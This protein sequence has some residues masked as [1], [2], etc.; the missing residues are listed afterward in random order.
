MS[1]KKHCECKLCSDHRRVQRIK[2]RG[3]VDKM[4]TLIDELEERLFMSE[5][6]LEVD[7]AILAGTWPSAKEYALGILEKCAKRETDLVQSDPGKR[8]ESTG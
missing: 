3:N 6:E 7:E 5:F 4:R 2:K 8:W 1:E